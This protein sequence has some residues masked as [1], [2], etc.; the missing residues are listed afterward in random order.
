MNH[1]QDLASREK[2][3]LGTLIEFNGH[4][5]LPPSLA[6]LL[7]NAPE[8]F[9][10]GRHGA[11]AA[12]LLDLKLA[13]LPVHTVSVSERLSF[14]NS[15]LLVAEIANNAFPLDIAEIEADTI[16]EGWKTRRYKLLFHEAGE[17][18]DKNP[19]LHHAIVQNVASTIENLEAEGHRDG[20]PDI[21]DAAHYLESPAQLPPQL[22]EQIVHLSTKFALGGG[23][24]SFKSWTFLNIGY[25]LATGTDWLGFHTRQ[26]RVLI[27]NLE[28]AP[29]FM[30]HRVEQIARAK[31]TPLPP[32][33]L[34]IWNLRGFSARHD[35]IIPK[36]IRRIKDEAIEC[37]I[38]DPSYKLVPAGDDENS[39]TD[40]NAMMTSFEHISVDTGATTMFGAHFAKGNASMKEHIDRISGSGVYARDPDTILTF[41]AQETPDCYSVE[42]THRNL[43]PIHPFVVRWCYP[44]FALAPELDPEKLKAPK[45]GRPIKHSVKDLLNLLGTNRLSTTQLRNLADAKR[46]MS[47]STFYDLLSTAINTRKIHESAI[48]HLLEATTIRT[49]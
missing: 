7:N 38:I 33:N 30:H 12:A 48:D 42:I 21:D 39:A 49:P 43:P 32:G 29:A 26:C 3:V 14:P 27:L 5:T 19:E 46:G 9:S 2:S 20:L 40:I 34:Q 23:S 18:L 16:W 31:A 41:T 25:S 10:D 24:K 15:S 4:G 28:I 44:C 11:I 6:Q 47:K 22:I 36:I 17:T 45:S 35:I 1:M 37:V 13:N 8:C